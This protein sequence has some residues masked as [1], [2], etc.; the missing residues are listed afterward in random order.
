MKFLKASDYG[1]Y[2]FACHCDPKIDALS[3][4]NNYYR[5]MVATLALLTLIKVEHVL[6]EYQEIIIVNWE[7]LAATILPIL[8]F[9]SYR[10]QFRY[11]KISL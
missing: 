5:S 1:D 11:I 8:V 4:T 10:K 6:F 2:I 9:F 7:W 3:K